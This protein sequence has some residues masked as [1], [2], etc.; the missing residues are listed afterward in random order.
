MYFGEHCGGCRNSTQQ[1]KTLCRYHPEYTIYK[2]YAWQLHEMGDRIGPNDMKLS[3]LLW[4]AAGR[5]TDFHKKELELQKM[6]RNK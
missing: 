1:H 5:M 4:E 6:R 2:E 3:N